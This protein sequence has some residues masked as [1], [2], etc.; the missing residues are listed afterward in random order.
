MELTQLRQFK[1]LAECSSMTQA[2][3]KLH[4]SQPALS[5]ALKK[6]E[7]ELETPLFERKR[8]RMILNDAGKLALTYAGAIIEKA[9]EMKNIF[10]RYIRQNNTLL[11]GF[12]DPGPMRLSVPLFQKSCPEIEVSSEL[13][14]SEDNAP[15]NLLS[16]KYDIVISLRELK[17]PDIVSMPFAREELM[18]SVP[19]QDPLAAEKQICLHDHQTRKIA[20]YSI[21]GAYERRISPFM[22]WLRT[23]PSVTF[24]TDYFVFQQL[25]N[26]KN[27]LTFTTRLVRQYRNDGGNR[28][29]I[30]LTDEG[31][32]AVYWFSFLRENKKRAAPFID[33]QRQNATP[34]LGLE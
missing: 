9:D 8:S 31:I 7:D 29:V 28:V 27:V 30:P 10:R 21:D 26:H 32:S 34:L 23:L 20:V 1:I 5:A 12:C 25:L 18:L 13:L 33:W 2:A 3:E 16:H 11:L 4:I 14:T 15:N 17:H 6:L 19:A 24:Y 22:N